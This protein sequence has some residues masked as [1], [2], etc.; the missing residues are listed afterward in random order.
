MSRIRTHS[1]P[2]TIKFY[3]FTYFSFLF[4][5][6]T[7]CILPSAT[8]AQ[9]SDSAKGTKQTLKK[10]A[11]PTHQLRDEPIDNESSGFVEEYPISKLIEIRSILTQGQKIKPQ[12]K[13]SSQS[14]LHS[15]P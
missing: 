7:N 3:V 8:L 9:K 6:L 15:L 4:L 11:Y 13:N 5:Q 10:Q 2:T 14:L 12:I 1:C